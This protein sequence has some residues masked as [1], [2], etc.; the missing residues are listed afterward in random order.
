MAHWTGV[1]GRVKVARKT[2]NLPI[3]TSPL[4][5]AKSKTKKKLFSISTRRLVESVE[6]LKSSLAQS[7]GVL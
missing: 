2:Q 6:G 7:V 3:V 1:Q 4:E 5:N